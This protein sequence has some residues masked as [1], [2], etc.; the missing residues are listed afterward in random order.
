VT[1]DAG[2]DV[3]KEE[4][5]SIVGGIASLYNLSGNQ[6][7]GSSKNWMISFQFLPCTMPC[8]SYFKISEVFFLLP[9]AIQILLKEMELPV[10]FLAT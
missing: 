7:G 2:K 5:S 10:M 8:G 6:S 9:I 3:E 4:R 1:A